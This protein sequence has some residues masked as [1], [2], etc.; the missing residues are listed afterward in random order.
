MMLGLSLPAFTLLHVLISLVAIVAGLAVAA[1]MLA[2]RRMPGWTILFLATTILTS[3]TGFMFPFERVLPSHIVGALSLAILAIACFALYARQLAGAWRGTYVIAAL[4]ALW[5]NVFVL[6]AQAFLKIGALHALAPTQNEPVFLVTQGVVA[7][8]FVV[9]GVRVF[10]AFHPA[11]A[12]GTLR[13][14]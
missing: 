2:A 6:V 10:R 14:A 1:G 9:L 5:L 13:M 12:T 8:A 4:V 7:L 3:V 11:P